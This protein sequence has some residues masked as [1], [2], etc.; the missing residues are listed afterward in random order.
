MCGL[1]GIF[2]FKNHMG[3]PMPESQ[4]ILK[5]LKHRGLDNQ[6]YVH[7][8]NCS[9]FHARLS[10]IDTS[11]KGN[12]PLSDE[13]N[14]LVYNG[15]IFNY[16][17]FSYSKNFPQAGDAEVLFDLLKHENKNCLNN[18]NGFFALAFYNAKTHNILV[19]RDRLGIKPL[20]Y[21]KNDECVAF[22]SEL[23]PLLKLIGPQKINQHQLNAYFRLNYCAGNET[24]FENVFR[25]APGHFIEATTHS[26][27][28]KKWYE[29]PLQK[30]SENL[31]QL[32]DN[33][34][35]TR[36]HADVPVGTFLSGGIDSSIISALAAKH[37]PDL[38]TFSIGFKNEHFFDETHYAELVATHIKS[39]HHVFKLSE[40]DFL[41]NIQSFLNC[42]DEPFADSSAFNFYMLTKFT[43]QFVK[44]A[45]SGD[46][47]DE[48]FKGYNKHKALFFSSKNS[49]KNN[50]IQIASPSLKIFPNSRDGKLSNKLR[51]L[52]KYSK[53]LTLSDLEKQK[54]L[55]TISSEKEVG[56]LLLQKNSADY[57]SS[58]FKIGNVYRNFDLKDTFDLQT[59]L[60]DD[61]LVKA[62][63]FS[64]QHGV[65]IRNPFLDYRVV[66]YALNL[67]Q[68]EKI[69]MAG[70]KLILKKTFHHL[71]PQEIFTRK[72][73]GFELPLQK[74]LTGNL[75]S[76]V[77]NDWLNIEKIR[78]ENMLS[79]SYIFGLQQRLNSSSPGDSA[80]QLWAVIVFENW[81][82]NFKEHIS[83]NV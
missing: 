12:Q 4:D 34:V 65:E 24:I 9:F 43:K 53:L 44:V 45:L 47:A 33:A 40:D 27:E 80:A 83:P 20:Y 46:G 78:S 29:A 50:I 8:H 14:Y 36:L 22:A 2:Y 52:K 11:D 10:V 13:E 25:L 39:Q 61:M 21:F 30:K 1:A 74:W 71:L 59:V 35:Q 15:E 75:R 73:K 57:F 64:M 81:L 3:A 62:D 42:I 7:V 5:L 66:E 51:Q 31:F 48:L 77:E 68:N 41:E 18:L 38:H 16:K 72:K 56:Q 82:Q 79:T 37:K 76:T 17:D 55:A 32:L 49:F 23:K 28:I 70:Q 67:S 19:A 6:Q 60:S 63:R 58:L 26:F 54:F 69:S